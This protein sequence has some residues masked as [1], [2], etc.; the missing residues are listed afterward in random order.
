M[1][2]LVRQNAENLRGRCNNRSLHH[3]GLSAAARLKGTA[4]K[5]V[6]D[7]GIGK[8]TADQIFPT[9]LV[10]A[11]E[12]SGVAE[13]HLAQRVHKAALGEHGQVGFKQEEVCFRQ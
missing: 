13:A 9:V 11:D 12:N 5:A 1:G 2:E 8:T 4:K 6:R 3:F 7:A 10:I